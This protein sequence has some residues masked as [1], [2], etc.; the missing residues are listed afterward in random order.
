MSECNECKFGK[1]PYQLYIYHK[2]FLTVYWHGEMTSLI[3]KKLKREKNHKN[4]K[5]SFVQL[6]TNFVFF[7]GLQN[8]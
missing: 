5:L 3:K 2:Q 7:E 1:N 4:Y 6:K 8:F